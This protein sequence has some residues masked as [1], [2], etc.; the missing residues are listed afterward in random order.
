VTI[1]RIASRGH[2]PDGEGAR[3]YGS[4]WTPRGMRAVFASA[5]LSLA[6]LERFIHTDPDLEPADL[7]AVGIDSGPG[8]HIESVDADDLPAN[9]REYPAPSALASIGEQWLRQARTAA[10]SVPSV[11]I[12]RERNFILNPAHADFER[13]RVWTPEPFAFDPRMWKKR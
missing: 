2:A 10:L 13:L 3:L 11:V 6:V 7:V 12:P 9:W 4:R 8:I 1:W 5:T